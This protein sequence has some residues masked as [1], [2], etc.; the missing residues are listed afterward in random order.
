MKYSLITTDVISKAQN[1]LFQE[2]N[3]TILDKFI[4][5]NFSNIES[6]ASYFNVS[7]NNQFNIM[8]I[9]KNY[10]R[11]LDLILQEGNYSFFDIL[12]NVSQN[13]IDNN[14]KQFN[15]F[16][17]LFINRIT[18]EKQLLFLVEN[19]YINK[20][21]YYNIQCYRKCD[22]SK[23]DNQNDK[24]EL[25]VQLKKELQRYLT[26]R[27]L[28]I[29]IKKLYSDCNHYNK[30]DDISLANTND[31]YFNRLYNKGNLDEVYSIYDLDDLCKL[32]GI[33]NLSID[34]AKKK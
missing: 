28:Y 6:I 32:D 20:R 26:F 15:Y 4:Y 2:K 7:L 34:G 22:F 33:E 18:N 9:Y 30:S 3:L 27:K 16:L 24:R 21:I 11:Y 8:Y 12:D 17:D 14:S 23:N 31:E 25:Y 1:I 10:P 5:K 13:Y 19:G 29:G